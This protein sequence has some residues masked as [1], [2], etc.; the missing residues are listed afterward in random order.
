VLVT[1]DSAANATNAKATTSGPSDSQS[2]PKRKAPTA[3]TSTAATDTTVGR[4]VRSSVSAWEQLVGD[5][6]REA[7][8]RCRATSYDSFVG[9][10]ELDRS[11]SHR[12]EREAN[13]DC[14]QPDADSLPG[15][16]EAPATVFRV[17][18]RPRGPARAGGRRSMFPSATRRTTRRAHPPPPGRASPTSAPRRAARPASAPAAR[19]RA[20]E[21]D[22]ERL[23]RA[24]SREIDAECRHGDDGERNSRDEQ[25][26]PVAPEARWPAR[27]CAEACHWSVF[28]STNPAGSAGHQACRG[29][30]RHEA[31]GTPSQ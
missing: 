18:R 14:D 25:P 19:P 8:S 5:P 27:R 17:E 12:D 30:G 6:P 16:R 20:H 24:V 4:C 29:G 10:R 26:P 13:A 9:E 22:E 2:T 7:S 3:I 15:A 23:L 11:R 21:A 1:P 31:A 28:Q